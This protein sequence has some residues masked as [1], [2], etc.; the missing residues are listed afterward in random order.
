M[1]PVEY[2]FTVL[3]TGVVVHWRTGATRQKRSYILKEGQHKAH[4]L[5][6]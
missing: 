5:V 2:V 6:I 1:T 4:Q 3:P